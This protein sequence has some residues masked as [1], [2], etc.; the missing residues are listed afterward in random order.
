MDGTITTIL[1]IKSI[2]VAD[3]K[4]TLHKFIDNI[5]TCTISTKRSYILSSN[6]MRNNEPSPAALPTIVVE[7]DI[8]N[9]CDME[10]DVIVPIS[11]LLKI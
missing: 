3:S 5:F 1:L 4:V 7:A 8:A 6:N 11:E 9:D 2:D 10:L